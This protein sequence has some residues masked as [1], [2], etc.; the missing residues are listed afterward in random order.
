MIDKIKFKIRSLK[1]KL[2]KLKWS[3]SSKKDE[4][5]HRET[6]YKKEKELSDRIK[7]VYGRDEE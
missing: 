7:R 6:T 5:L 4:Q 2:Y 1:I 3:I